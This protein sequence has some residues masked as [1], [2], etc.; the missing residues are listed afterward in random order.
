MLSENVVDLMLHRIAQDQRR[1]RKRFE[2]RRID[3]EYQTALDRA[4]GRYFDDKVKYA[5]I[6][7]RLTDDQAE[8]LILTHAFRNEVYHVGVQHE[9]IAVVCDKS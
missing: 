5:R 6:T 1:K 8:V 3:Y 4:L 9:D 2:Y 7:G